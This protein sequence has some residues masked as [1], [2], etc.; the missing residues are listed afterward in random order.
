LQEKEEV[1]AT[2]IDGRSSGSYDASLKQ[3]IPGIFFQGQGMYGRPRN[4]GSRSSAPSKS[5]YQN[6]SGTV[7][8]GKNGVDR[9]GNARLCNNCQSKDHFI[10]N[11]DKPK[12]ILRNVAQQ[13]TK[14]P[15]NVRNILYEMCLQTE[16]ALYTEADDEYSAFFNNTGE[17]DE[18]IFDSGSENDEDQCKL[19]HLN[20]NN[21]THIENVS[22][23]LCDG[24][25]PA[26]F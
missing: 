9:F 12:T 20:H 18:K 22:K 8:S 26:D 5:P 14:N 15:E 10:R 13:L 4:P 6:A 24:I 2:Q 16:D 17:K 25:D 11:C 3:I 23:A 19:Y 21:A 1:E 7:L